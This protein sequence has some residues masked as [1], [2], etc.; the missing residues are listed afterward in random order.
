[1]GRTDES[2]AS[3][4]FVPNIRKGGVTS[5]PPFLGREVSK[6][7]P[8]GLGI[9]LLAHSKIVAVCPGVLYKIRVNVCI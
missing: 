8:Q 2:G 7:L 6:R 5:T 4:T 9:L 1:M 3:S